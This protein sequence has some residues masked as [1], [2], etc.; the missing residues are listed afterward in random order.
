MLSVEQSPAFTSIEKAADGVH[1]KQVKHYVRGSQTA[2]RPPGGASGPVGGRVF[3]MTDIFIVNEI[4]TQ[5]K[6]LFW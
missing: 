2:G 6:I 4:W 5:S 3:C 1:N